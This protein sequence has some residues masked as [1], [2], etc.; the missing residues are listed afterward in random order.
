M[1]IAGVIFIVAAAF[2]IYGIRVV[3]EFSKIKSTILGL[4]MCIP[5]YTY[6]A[7][8]GLNSVLG[9][10]ATRFVMLGIILGGEDLQGFTDSMILKGIKKKGLK[11]KGVRSEFTKKDDTDLH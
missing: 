1:I 9:F 11:V 8:A 4:T 5:F 10:L 7:I 6:I 3:T 2:M